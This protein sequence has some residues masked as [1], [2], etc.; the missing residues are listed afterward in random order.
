MVS[1]SAAANY[2]LRY[3]VASLGYNRGSNNGGGY[4]IGAESDVVH[5]SFSRDIGRVYNV[6]LTGSYL[7]TA[8]GSYLHAAGQ[9]YSG[10]TNARYGGAQATRRLG[11]YASVYATYTAI[12]Q[13]SSSLLPSTAVNRLMQVISFG[14]GY[15]PRATHLGH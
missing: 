8:G 14:I 15:T 10:V 12:D 4:L 13:S 9:P 2:Q 11:R 1:V 7:R 6:A 3:G 5:A